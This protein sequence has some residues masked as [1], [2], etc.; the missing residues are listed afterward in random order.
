MESFARNAL[1]LLRTPAMV[2]WWLRWQ[3]RK[4]GFSFGMRIPFGGKIET[5]HSFSEFWSVC[6]N[7]PSIGES[8]LIERVVRPSTVNFDVGA[9]VG[10]FTLAMA[11]ACPEAD[12]FSFEPAPRTFERLQKSVEL[13]R[14]SNAHLRQ[15]AIGSHANRALFEIDPRS[16]ATNRLTTPGSSSRNC[17]EVEIQTIDGNLAQA[18]GREL[19][20]LKVDVEGFEC[21][22]LMGAA[23]SIRK[24]RWAAVLI[25]V[26]PGNLNRVGR[27]V[28]DLLAICNSLGCSLFEL[29]ADGKAG[30]ELTDK[31]LQTITLADA[32]VS[33]S[34]AAK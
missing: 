10:V 7:L 6:Q 29:G 27:S 31:E 4:C 34:A 20:L 13:N 14:V 3:M 33:K 5:F 2:P 24:N 18:E 28:A 25:E 11:K 30:R 17:I 15:A 23:D 8:R 9:N 22:V 12:V 1:T 16:P 26:C 21:D 19:G 32:L